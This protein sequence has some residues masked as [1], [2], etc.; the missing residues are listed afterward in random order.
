MENHERV[1]SAVQ[2]V[3]RQIQ[4]WQDAESNA[5]AWVRHWGFKGARQT[6]GGADGGVDIRGRGVVGQVK[7]QATAVGRPELQRLVGACALET[8]LT[9]MFFTGSSYSKAAHE[10]AGVVGI[11]LFTYD[12]AGVMTPANSPARRIMS[13]NQ[14]GGA[15]GGKLS[16]SVSE[17]GSSLRS[18]AAVALAILVFSFMLSEMF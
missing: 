18:L 10:Y 16:G 15:A 9:V 12:L 5:A 7:Y 11:A 4:S 8:D 1:P 13:T 2:P 6:P 3:A 17:L 14:R